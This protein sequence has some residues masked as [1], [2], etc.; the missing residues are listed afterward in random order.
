MQ[1]SAK[2]RW[3]NN[4]W[5][6]IISGEEVQL[7]LG[8]DLCESNIEESFIRNCAGTEA[9]V[10]IKQKLRIEDDVLKNIN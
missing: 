10:Y 9:G 8:N 7:I 1:H 6:D 4:S 2:G 3:R 5:S